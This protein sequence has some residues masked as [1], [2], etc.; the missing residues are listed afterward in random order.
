MV[1]PAGRHVFGPV[2]SRRLG[3]SLGIDPVPL[4]TCNFNCVYC[5]L[6]QTPRP[7]AK[8]RS[9]VPMS[10]ILAE[11]ASVLDRRADTDI[12]WITFVGSGETTLCSRIG[13]LIRYVKSRSGHPV[14]VIT[15]GS[16]LRLAAVRRDLAAADAVL[17]SLDAGSEN[18]YLRINRPRPEFSFADHVDGLTRFRT[19]YRGRLW[20]EVMVIDGVND[21]AEALHD[22]AA[23]LQRVEPDEIHLSTPTRP[24][25]EPWVGPPSQEALERAAAILG[26]VA[27]VLRPTAVNREAGIDGD[28]VDEV[29]AIISRHPLRELELDQMLTRWTR[30]QVEQTL[31]ILRTGREIQM[32]ER[33]GTSF[34]CAAEMVFPEPIPPRGLGSTEPGAAPEARP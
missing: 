30:R 31:G 13:P 23:A 29:L 19:E 4:K 25:A 1:R 3:L 6:G 22:I 33:F 15:N 11:I 34:W 16:L 18:L 26:R 9:F 12:D 24:P 7:V 10:K 5:Q 14:A 17:P 21:S 32:V 8:R 27:P 2:S 20:V 28:L